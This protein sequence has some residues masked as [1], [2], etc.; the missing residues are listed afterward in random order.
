MLRPTHPAQGGAGVMRSSRR[1]GMVTRCSVRRR[2]QLRVGG[3]AS[4]LLR[5]AFDDVTMT[6]CS[7][8]TVLRTENVD[9]AALFGLIDRIE[10]MGLV[11]LEAKAVE[12]DGSPPT[13]E[14]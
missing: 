3:V 2:A 13:E 4:D 12:G 1:G 9:R 14:P 8:Q 6:E 10:S 7:G 5:A 11:L